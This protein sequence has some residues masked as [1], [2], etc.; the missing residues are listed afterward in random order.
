VSVKGSGHFNDG[1]FERDP[2]GKS[3]LFSAAGAGGERPMGGSLGASVVPPKMYDMSYTL[4]RSDRVAVLLGRKRAQEQQ[5]GER[6]WCGKMAKTVF[7]IVSLL[8]TASACRP[9]T[10]CS[11]SVPTNVCKAVADYTN[12]LLDHKVLAGTSL[13][14]EVLAPDEFA[15][16]LGRVNK[17]D[18]ELGLRCGNCPA[19]YVGAPKYQRFE[20]SWDSK[21]MFLRPQR[22]RDPFPKFIVVSTEE[23]EGIMPDKNGKIVSDGKF[24]LYNVFQFGRFIGAYYAGMRA[25][26]LDAEVVKT[27]P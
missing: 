5:P 3:I 12:T 22:T 27:L 8:L 7:A 17:E 15:K 24:D 18:E 6:R 4:A 21:V 20:N 19:P 25:V 10:S 1:S 9:Q 16:R 26:L 11:P 23:F 14:L 13:S 2:R